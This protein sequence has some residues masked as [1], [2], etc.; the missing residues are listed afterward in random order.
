MSENISIN[1]SV[2][3]LTAL[4]NLLQPTKDLKAVFQR[5]KDIETVTNKLL[6]EQKQAEAATSQA[7]RLLTQ[8]E[9]Q[10]A[11]Q[12][13]EIERL[14]EQ[15][16]NLIDEATERAKVSLVTVKAELDKMRL[17]AA[18]QKK[19]LTR[20][21]T[22]KT[23]T[24][25]QI[26]KKIEKAQSNQRDIMGGAQQIEAEAMRQNEQLN[27]NKQSLERDVANAQAHLLQLN[28][29]IKRRETNLDEAKRYEAER[30]QAADAAHRAKQ[31]LS[32]MQAELEAK[33][34]ELTDLHNAT[35]LVK[36]EMAA[37][38]QET[39]TLQAKRGQLQG[40]IKRL[41]REARA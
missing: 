2:A 11:E 34:M 30:K 15:K 26:N 16:S 8:F 20:E 35:R 27:R 28:S 18:N 3:A 23:A 6:A 14:G 38:A 21:I 41:E 36:E 40:E 17:S 37:Y 5:A 10:I 39:Q 7:K 22:D 9:K 24:L 29:E 1:D 12:R 33:R 25:E 4:E 19:Q 31:E 13:G 32:A